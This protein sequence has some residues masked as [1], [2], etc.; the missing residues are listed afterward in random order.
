MRINLKE[1]AEF[2]KS[3]KDAVIITHQSPDGD[4]IGAGFA[5]RDILAMLGI[6]SRVICSDEFPKR[7]AFMT[8][9]GWGEDFEPQTVIAV[10]IAD[11][12]LMG[13]LREE[14]ENKVDL[15]IDHHISNIEYAERL[16]LDPDAAA[17]CE[18]IYELA[19]ELGAL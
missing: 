6:R 17:T 16:L 10:D 7:Y 13:N 18:L 19:K 5:L 14:Y 11:T 4:C 9:T 2:L 15:C 12:Q 3:C 8:K 1:A